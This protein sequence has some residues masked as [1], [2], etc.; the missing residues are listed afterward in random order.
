MTYGALSLFVE[1]HLLPEQTAMFS[2][3]IN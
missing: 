3:N 2:R 1:L